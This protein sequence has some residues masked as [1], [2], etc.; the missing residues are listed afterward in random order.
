MVIKS[1]ITQTFFVAMETQIILASVKIKKKKIY[2]GFIYLIKKYWFQ[3]QHIQSPNDVL[4]AV[5]DTL[6]LC[7]LDCRY[8]FGLSA[9]QKEKDF[10]KNR[11]EK[12]L[13][14][15]WPSFGPFP[16]QTLKL[17]LGLLRLTMPRFYDLSRGHSEKPQAYHLG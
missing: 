1:C 14:K 15:C 5:L 17:G 6:S 10:S 3:I 16:K 2:I 13:V 9:H 7:L 12:F 4:K 11:D 8:Q